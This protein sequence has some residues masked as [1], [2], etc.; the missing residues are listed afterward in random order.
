VS[1]ILDYILQGPE[2]EKIASRIDHTIAK[3]PGLAW[4]NRLSLSR[5]KSLMQKTNQ[6]APAGLAAQVLN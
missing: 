6:E 1:W 5:A 4:F 3:L 2:G